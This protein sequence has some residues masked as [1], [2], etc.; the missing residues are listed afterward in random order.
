VDRNVKVNNRGGKASRPK[1][2]TRFEHCPQCGRKGVYR[3]RGRYCR[4]RYCGLYRILVP[5]TDFGGKK[6][7]L[8]IV[9]K[10]DKR[11]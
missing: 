9:A 4:C 6:I 11:R 5:D 1:E 2:G 8:A 7:F 3:V 10:R